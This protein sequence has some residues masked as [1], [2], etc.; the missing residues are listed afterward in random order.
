VSFY[1][2]LPKGP[3]TASASGGLKARFFDGKNASAAPLLAT[4]LGIF[5][6]GYTID[7]QSSSPSITCSPQA[8][9]VAVLFFV[10]V[11]SVHLSMWCYFLSS[12][13][14]K[15]TL[16]QSTT[17]TTPTNLSIRYS[18]SRAWSADHVSH[19]GSQYKSITTC[20]S[21]SSFCRVA[22]QALSSLYLLKRFQTFPSATSYR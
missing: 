9:D 6:I 1:S 18:I 21:R 13:S 12:S 5:G 14:T 4:I 7:Y 19:F 2:K 22:R 11:S 3:Q 15:L 20:P 8:D 10:F 17:R 16:T